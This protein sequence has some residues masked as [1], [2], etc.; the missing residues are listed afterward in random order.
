MGQIGD[1][2][3]CFKDKTQKSEYNFEEDNEIIKYT[4]SA[5]N[6][7]DGDDILSRKAKAHLILQEDP[8]KFE[9]KYPEL[10][11]ER[12]I[13]MIIKLQS[14]GRGVLFRNEFKQIIKKKLV[15]DTINLL[16]K[17][18]QEFRTNNLFKAEN[19]KSSVFDPYGW[20]KFYSTTE[21][22]NSIFSPNFG[23]IYNCKLLILNKGTAIYSGQLNLKNEKHGFGVLLTKD[24]MKY[25]G[26]WMNNKFTCWGKFIDV[27][28]TIFIGKYIFNFFFLLGKF[29]NGKL[30]G[31]GEKTTLSKSTYVGEFQNNLKHGFGVDENPEHIY[32]GEFRL[33]K[34]EGKGKLI[35][36]SNQDVYEGEFRDNSITGSGFYTWSNKDTYKGTFI[37][38]KMDGKGLYR[39]PDGGEY[40]GEYKNNIKEGM[41][42]FKWANGKIYEGPFKQ[43]KPHGVGKLYIND[44]PYDVEFRDGKLCQNKDKVSSMKSNS[45]YS[46]R[47]NI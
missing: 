13:N 32:E 33:D 10:K 27:D 45:D 21:E 22:N 19:Y 1:K 31:F 17:H 40:Y 24:G 14:L 47:K 23:N 29:E 12:V 18:T 16:E 44:L 28:G 15:Q 35:Y 6:N 38:G 9:L 8:S 39:W 41:G 5:K 26:A 20:K 37:N 36:K 7:F 25:E 11:D 43:G 4:P 46:K 30:N 2:C 34:K 3:N 42:K